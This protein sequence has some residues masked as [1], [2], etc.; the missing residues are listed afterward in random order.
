MQMLLRGG[1]GG[2]GDTVEHQKKKL[3]SCKIHKLTIVSSQKNLTP[4][5]TR[6]FMNTRC[7]PNKKIQTM[8]QFYSHNRYF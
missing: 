1:G 7:P 3:L 2:G 8:Q 4:Q 6:V 5:N